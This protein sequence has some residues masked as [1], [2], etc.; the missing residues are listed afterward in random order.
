[1]FERALTLKNLLDSRRAGIIC[2]VIAIVNK[3][4][5]AW[6]YSSLK[7]DKALYLLFAKSFLETGRLAEPVTVFETG[8]TVYLYD[9]AIHSPLYS[10]LCVPFLWI[11]KSYF[12]AQLIVSFLSWIIFFTALYKLSCLLFQQLWIAHLFI[13]CSG[14]FLYP[15]ELIS[16]PKDTLAA[17]LTLWSIILVHQFLI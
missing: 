12:I 1:M 4:T 8:N 15:H 11:T 10:L 2:L 7:A 3:S 9:S 16:G 5:I 17:G 6:L 14:F 13:L